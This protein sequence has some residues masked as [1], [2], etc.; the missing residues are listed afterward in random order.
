[1]C[2]EGRGGFS[3]RSPNEKRSERVIIL[4]EIIK[5]FE[6]MI[7][8]PDYKFTHGKLRIIQV[9]VGKLCNLSCKHCHVDAGPNR[10]EIMTRETMQHILRLL[11]L[12]AALLK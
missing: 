3:S 8:N 5:N 12:L 1:M 6:S 7:D 4:S 9:N 10:T 11:T 2:F